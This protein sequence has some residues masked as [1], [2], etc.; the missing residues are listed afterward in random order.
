[1]IPSDKLDSVRKCLEATRTGK[2]ISETDLLVGLPVLED[3]L[4]TIKA[5]RYEPYSL[6]LSDLHYRV[7]TLRGILNTKRGKW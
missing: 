2:I 7:N 5:L 6:L 3:F 4:E 1:M